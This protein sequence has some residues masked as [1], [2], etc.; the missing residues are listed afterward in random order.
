MHNKLR[1]SLVAGALSAELLL[2]GCSSS[3]PSEREVQIQAAIAADGFTGQSGAYQYV[4]PFDFDE[5]TKYIKF[6]TLNLGRCGLGDVIANIAYGEDDTVTD[7]YDYRLTVG[8][9]YAKNIKGGVRVAEPGITITFQNA[10]EYQTTLPDI[11]C[12]D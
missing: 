11:V 7:V 3:Q 10:E 9:V 5:S 4:E 12:Q 6:D 8:T 2:A 1:T